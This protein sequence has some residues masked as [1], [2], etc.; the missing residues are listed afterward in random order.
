[1]NS[2]PP[3]IFDRKLLRARRER[4]GQHALGNANA[5]D[6]LFREIADQLCDRLLDFKRR[7]PL[8]LELGARDGVL[9]RERGERGGIETLVRCDLS[10]ALLRRGKPGLLVAADEE[11]L[12]F[13]GQA[14]DL[15][16]SNLCLHWANDLPGALAQIRESLRPDGLF[17]ASLLGAG[18]LAE[19]RQC[20]I[21][22][23]AQ[24]KG[25]ASLRVAPFA[26]LRDGAGLLQR[27]GFA[28][29]VADG[30]TITATYADPLR[31]LADLR[32]MG[33][34][35]ALMERSRRPTARAIFARAMALYRE[36]F[37]GPDG[38]VPAT[39][40]VLF[41]SGWAPHSSQQRPAK[42]GSGK[43]GFGEAL[44]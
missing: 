10:S 43:I 34:T 15:V 6:F 38:R 5:P 4:L 7:F 30:A 8:A 26:D 36:R 27:A 35:N 11:L 12:P 22:A 25:G 9:D 3:L 18:T 2:A 16:L 40:Q 31:L 39:F 20:L 32:A 17:L 42:R 44:G 24:E 14:F 28:L 37:A 29:P 19:L 41:L 13:R 23:E 33:E 1:M 21:E